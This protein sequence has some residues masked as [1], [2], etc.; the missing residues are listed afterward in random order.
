MKR[1]RL[2]VFSNKMRARR[3]ASC[4]I[5]Q[6]A[7]L[8]RARCVQE[9]VGI[10]GYMQKICEFNFKVKLLPAFVEET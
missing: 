4:H 8:Y 7:A 3:K 2:L 10:V 1:L 5:V 9:F 6:G